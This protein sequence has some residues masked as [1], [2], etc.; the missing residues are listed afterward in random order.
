MHCKNHMLR[1]VYDTET[2]VAVA[3]NSIKPYTTIVMFIFDRSMRLMPT[4]VINRHHNIYVN[5]HETDP[6]LTRW[7]MQLVHDLSRGAHEGNR[8]LSD[9]ESQ[10]PQLCLLLA[11]M[12][13][14]AGAN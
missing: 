11:D 2:L 13:Y 3:D 1:T 12:A 8:S 10:Q 6:V 14:S 5:E 7:C 9:T 4:S